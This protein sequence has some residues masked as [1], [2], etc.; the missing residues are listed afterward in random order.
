MRYKGGIVKP[1]QMQIE[2][3]LILSVTVKYEQSNKHPISHYE[4]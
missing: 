4:L 1:D 2:K 3:W